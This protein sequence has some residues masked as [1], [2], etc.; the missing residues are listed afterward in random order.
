MFR[1][2]VVA[3]VCYHH[4]SVELLVCFRFEYYFRHVRFAGDGARRSFRLGR[5][6]VTRRRVLITI[7]SA[8]GR[9]ARRSVRRHVR[10]AG[11]AERLH[12][13]SLGLVPDIRDAVPSEEQQ[14]SVDELAR[15]LLPLGNHI[16]FH[17]VHDALSLVLQLVHFVLEPEFL[18]L[19][20][21]HVQLF[22]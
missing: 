3:C 6:A 11:R 18:F 20:K 14:E 10:A 15:F 19:E 9:P 17:L 8:L 4:S 1:S 12:Q 13:A 22:G 7:V 16:P 2:E 21:A 5:I